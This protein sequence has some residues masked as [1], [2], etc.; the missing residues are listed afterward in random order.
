ME[1]ERLRANALGET[2]RTSGFALFLR[3]GM[4]GWL[5]CVARSAGSDDREDRLTGTGNPANA[6]AR[7]MASVLVDALLSREALTSAGVCR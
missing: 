3:A 5:R 2:N 6:Q 4:A 7:S 1:Y